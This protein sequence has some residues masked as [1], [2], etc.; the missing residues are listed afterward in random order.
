MATLSSMLGGN[1]SSVKSIQRGIT[2]STGYTINVTISAV[3][4]AK[5]LLFVP[6]STAY[7]A[8]S[9]IT[10]ATNI[11]M[12]LMQTYTYVDWQLIEYN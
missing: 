10:S 2:Y 9:R 12:E 11:Q 8:T 3:N 5:S 7:N 6:G 4:P 1:S